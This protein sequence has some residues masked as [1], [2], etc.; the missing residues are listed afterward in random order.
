MMFDAATDDTQGLL[1]L[2]G[3]P[4]LDAAL[5]RVFPDRIAV[6]SSFG[7]EAAVLLAQVA[8]I[9]PATPVLFIDTLRHFPETLAYRDALAARLGLTQVRSLRPE[10]SALAETDPD[11]TLAG[12]H[13]DA[14]CAMRKVAPLS[15]ALG[16]F[17]AW[18]S[19]R[20]RYQHAG[21]RLLP[22]VQRVDGR[23]KINPLAGWTREQVA[24]AYRRLDLPPHPLTAAGFRSIG[25]APCTRPIASGED[26][27]A[28][29]WEGFAK[30]E[31]GIH[32]TPDGRLVRALA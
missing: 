17:D 21:R 16:R 1:G 7:A 30:T 11:E 4:L 6:V 15:A 8:R 29:R 5:T 19:G 9:A 2:D 31:C 18:V 20:K 24:E 28:G 13:P 12:T 25:C 3:I 23:I 26:E 27:R 10:P 32:R 22:S 14:C